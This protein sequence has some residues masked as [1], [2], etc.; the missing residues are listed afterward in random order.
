MDKLIKQYPFMK[1]L[2]GGKGKIAEML[3]IEGLGFYGQCYDFAVALN[4]IIGGRFVVNKPHGC[5][6]HVM[7]EIDG[8]LIDANGFHDEKE[9][10]SEWAYTEFSLKRDIEKYTIPD[11]AKIIRCALLSIGTPS[12]T[13][14]KECTWKDV[15]ARCPCDEMKA[16]KGE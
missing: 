15:T 5:V 13:K 3:G 9:W 8:F 1:V 6:D 16:L 14:W 11:D 10:Q 2:A 4:S 7:I 12:F